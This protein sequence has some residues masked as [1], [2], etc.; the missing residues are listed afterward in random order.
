M[1][2]WDERMVELVAAGAAA[3][4][5]LPPE[6]GAPDRPFA[7]A[8]PLIVFAELR[9]YAN[10]RLRFLE[11]GSGVGTFTIMADLLG[12]R[13]CGIERDA[14]L[15]AASRRIAAQ[16][17]SHAVF[18]EGNFVPSGSESPTPKDIPAEFF[19]PEAEADGYAPFAAAA[20]EF[21][22]IYVFPHPDLIDWAHALFA[23]VARPNARLLLYCQIGHML[24]CVQTRDGAERLRPA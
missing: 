15:V 16:F 24:T 13:A 11:W 21:D 19:H 23:R 17:E 12:Y 14:R 4:A 10:R 6:Y 7:A 9:K 1:S 20:R 3:R 22:V 5:A 2:R 8:D 18:S